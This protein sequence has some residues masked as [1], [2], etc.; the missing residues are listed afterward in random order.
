MQINQFLRFLN[1]DMV[2]GV[3]R[4]LLPNAFKS[5]GKTG[6][7]RK[8]TMTERVKSGVVISKLVLTAIECKLLHERGDTTGEHSM[9]IMSY[10]A[11]HLDE[12]DLVD[13]Y[14]SS[15]NW[16]VKRALQAIGWQA[17]DIPKLEWDEIANWTA[18]ALGQ[19]MAQ[20]QIQQFMQRARAQGLTDEQ[21]IE[22]WQEFQRATWA[23]EQQSGSQ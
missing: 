15:S 14:P 1:D 10:V 22:I 2:V 9:V 3:A 12:V 21:I 19:G 17:G 20:I 16:V 5:R 23:Q 7:P 13:V 11:G 18:N 4:V 6:R 8:Y